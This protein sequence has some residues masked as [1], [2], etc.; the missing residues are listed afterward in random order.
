M[1]KTVLMNLITSSFAGRRLNQPLARLLDP[2]E[3]RTDRLTKHGSVRFVRPV[4]HLAS[5]CQDVVVNW[6]CHPRAS[7]IASHEMLSRHHLVLSVANQAN[8]ETREFSNICL[9][10]FPRSEDGS[11]CQAGCTPAFGRQTLRSRN[12]SRARPEGPAT[13]PRPAQNACGRKLRLARIAGLR[14]ARLGPQ[15]RARNGRQHIGHTTS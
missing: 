3:S 9:T 15:A 5:P 11:D 6:D 2:L 1:P 10:R 14:P 12:T 7:V 4:C 13:L 8:C